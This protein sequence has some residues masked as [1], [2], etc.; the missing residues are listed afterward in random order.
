MTS[1]IG[2][3]GD[4]QAANRKQA[5]HDN[6]DMHRFQP[7]P[8]LQELF[9]RQ[10]AEVHETTT[11]SNASIDYDALVFGD[12][13]L[14]ENIRHVCSLIMNIRDSSLTECS[15]EDEQVLHIDYEAIFSATNEDVLDKLTVPQIGMVLSNSF[16][17]HERRAKVNYSEQFT[18]SSIPMSL[19]L[20]DSNFHQVDTSP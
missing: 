9:D 10:E 2:A 11:F 20:S 3:A 18:T 4:K 13:Q 6:D 19:S 14:Y 7:S 12:Q 17:A 16:D 1:E 8:K 15:N 5:D